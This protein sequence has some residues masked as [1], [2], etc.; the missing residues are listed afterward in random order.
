MN[1]ID[2]L[3][4][5]IKPPVRPSDDTN[6]SKLGYLES[7]ARNRIL[8]EL[9]PENQIPLQDYE[10][11]S[12]ESFLKA[13]PRRDAR[14]KVGRD[15][16]LAIL[17]L[18]ASSWTPATWTAKDLFLVRDPE[19]PVPQPYFRHASLRDSLESND[20]RSTST[21]TRASLFAIGVLLL[22]LVFRDQLENQSFRAALMG[23]DMMPT[24]ATD[25][26]TALMWQ[27]KVEEELGYDLADAIKR[28]LV[29]MFEQATTLDLGNSSFVQAVWQ[30]VVRP[31]D[32]FLTAWN[33]N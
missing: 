10:I 30:Q 23:A 16:A 11:N 3:C 13:T 8:L 25:L 26:A 17:S 14:L 12:L 2:D 9:D 31:I 18:G 20:P 29:C 15:L 24:A 7:R 32:S 19:V 6:T 22:E 4:Q 21:Q 33:R 27:Q 1:A 5:A 28:C